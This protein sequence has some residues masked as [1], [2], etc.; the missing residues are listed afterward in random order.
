MRFIEK[1]IAIW[2]AGCFLQFCLFA[3]TG[4]LCSG[5]ALP[6][7]CEQLAQY[8]AGADVRVDLSGGT[9]LRGHVLTLDD[10]GFVLRAGDERRI[11][12]DQVEKL[13]LARTA[14]RRGTPDPAEVRRVALALGVGQHVLVG[15]PHQKTLRGKIHS[16]GTD[17]FILRLDH[18]AGLVL[19]PYGDVGHLEKN[20]SRAAKIA[21]VVVA[22]VVIA[23]LIVGYSVSD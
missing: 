16:I 13:R 7:T 8:G 21:I 12:Y 2:T 6:A 1:L 15:I 14:Y 18:D 3:E 9:K 23:A 5:A 22:A 20:L 11:S 19:V 10:N 4:E 17:H